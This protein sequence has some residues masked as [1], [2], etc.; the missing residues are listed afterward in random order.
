MGCHGYHH[1][2]RWGSAADRPAPGPSMR[3]TE[4]ELDLRVSQAE[5]DE[6]TAELARHYAAGRLAVDE[7]E[8]RVA[9]ALQARIGRDFE[10]LLADLPEDRGVAP[11]SAAPAGPAWPRLNRRAIAVLAVVVLTILT[12]GWVLWLLVPAWI[13]AGN[14]R[15]HAHPSPGRHRHYRRPATQWM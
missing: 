4:D 8:E 14:G 10:P 2:D 9:A 11:R 15:G 13:I 5:R 12:E 1:R 3:L 6:V 7:Y